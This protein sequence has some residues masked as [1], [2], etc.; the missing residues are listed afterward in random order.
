MS[1]IFRL[2]FAYKYEAETGDVKKTKLEVFVECNTYTEA[3]SLVYAIAKNK[4]MDRFED[5]SYEII[6]TKFS[7]IDFINNHTLANDEVLIENR[8]EHF[9]E[10]ENDGFFII[11]VKFIAIDEKEK[12]T[13]SQYV[14]CDKSINSATRFIVDHLKSLNYSNFVVTDSKLD[15]ADSIFL[16]KVSHVKIMNAKNE[17]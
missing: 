9:F 8:I 4:S 2:K 15:A 16:S 12:D 10:G 11:K 14:V 6:K 1:S 3:E 17:A 5:Y 7:T 13:T